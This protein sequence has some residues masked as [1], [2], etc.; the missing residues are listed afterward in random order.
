MSAKRLAYLA[1]YHAGLHRLAR[2]AIRPAGLIYVLHRVVPGPATDGFD[3]NHELHVT[4]EVLG[5]L[6][7]A[8]RAEGLD[9]VDLDEAL[10]RLAG[11]AR[12][13]PFACLTFDDGYRDNLELALPVCAGRDA[14]LAVYVTTGFIDRSA[15]NWWY[16]IEALLRAVDSV[17]LDGG[18]LPAST[19]PE[20][21]AAFAV[22][23][24][25]LRAGDLAARTAI[26]DGLAARHGGRFREAAAALMMDRDGLAALA[27]DRR[28][29]IGAHTVSHPALARLDEAA[30]RA[31]MAASRAI[32]QDWLG[33]PVRHFAYPFGDT[34]SASA[35]EFR[36]CAELGF[37]S[38]T[39]TRFGNLGPGALSAPTAL[40]R[41]PVNGFDDPRT[42]AVKVSGLAAALRRLLA[43]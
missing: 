27:A 19:A 31:E 34:P 30:A 42:V 40:P 29:T 6:I 17:A 25:R 12:A 22:L 21:N 18:V 11:G 2:A 20:K 24:A 33:R 41:V 28:V 32:L 7:D 26:L 1:S 39:T 15:D 4:P 13:R 38:A 35:R 5:G 9:L 36:A 3:P 37:A 23:A 14:P 43:G 10:A 8:T 16:A